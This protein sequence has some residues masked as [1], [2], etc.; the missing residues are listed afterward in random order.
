MDPHIMGVA[1]MATGFSS[2]TCRQGE[3]DCLVSDTLK[4]I[5]MRGHSRPISP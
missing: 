5:A 3:T 1:G 2:P 4:G